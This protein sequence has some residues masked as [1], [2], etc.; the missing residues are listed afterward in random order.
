VQVPGFHPKYPPD[1]LA[2]R[3]PVVYKNSQGGGIAIPPQV[4]SHDEYIPLPKIR[5]QRRTDAVLTPYADRCE[6]Q[7]GLTRRVFFQTLRAMIATILTIPKVV[8]DWL[9]GVQEPDAAEEPEGLAGEHR[10]VALVDSAKIQAL[11]TAR[12]GS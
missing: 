7:C 10:R 5:K 9:C 12:S 8:D 11:P 1:P 2:A 3:L 6:R 4:M